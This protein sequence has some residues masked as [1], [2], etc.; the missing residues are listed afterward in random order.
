MR[1]GDAQTGAVGTVLPH[2][3]VVQAVD[4]LGNPVPDARLA[5]LPKTGSVPDSAIRTDSMGQAKVR[6]TLGHATGPQRMIVRAEGVPGTLELS[7]RARSG[8]PTKLEFL[9]L[10]TAGASGKSAA[11]SLTVQ[12][13][14]DYGNPI[15]DRTVRFRSA[16]G[17]VSPGG[18]TT[19][20][21]GQ[22]R[23]RWTPA[24]KAVKASLVAE[25]PGT[26]AQ[27]SLTLP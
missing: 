13:A 12:L 6:W 19:D 10:R 4:R 14:D 15:A 5:L 3:I 1:S 2:V 21:Q 16:S 25:V 24:R 9:P 20:A 22:A 26:E 11:K 23:V 27:A 8:K 17:A 18:A 7:A